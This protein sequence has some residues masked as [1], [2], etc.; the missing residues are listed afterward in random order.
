[1]AVTGTVGRVQCGM[2]TLG[3]MRQLAAALRLSQPQLAAWRPVLLYSAN[4]CINA[5]LVEP[6]S[7]GGAEPLWFRASVIRQCAPLLET[8]SW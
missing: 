6:S 5:S 7:D 4:A 1:M 8:R 3:K 2:A